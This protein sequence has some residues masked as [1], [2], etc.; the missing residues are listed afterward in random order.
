[1]DDKHF[2]QVDAQQRV[3]Q[4]QSFEQELRELENDDIVAL[5]P[6]QSEKIKHYH[7]QC[8]SSLSALY[9]VDTNH[10]SKQ[11][12]LGMKIASLFGA[13]TLAC[14]IVF[15][16]YQFWGYLTVPVQVTVLVLSPVVMFLLSLRFA[17]TEHTAYFSKIAA[18]LSLACF[19]LNLSMLG[20][21]FGV[22]PSPNAFLVWSGF[23]FILAYACNARLLL[24]FAITSLSSFIA[25]K[26]GTWS[27]LYWISFGDRPENFFIP[28][29]LLFFVPQ[30][31]NHAKL[32]GF[33]PVYRVLAMIMVF[34]PVLILSNW[35][36]ISYLNWSY[37]AIEVF[38]QIIGFALAVLAI[39]L[40]VK[41]SWNEVVQ[42]GNVFFMLFLYTKFYDWW[43]QWMPKS[44]FFLVLGLSA[45][46]ALFVFKRMRLSNHA[47][48]SNS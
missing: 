28:S 23:G 19:V 7:Q 27:G 24:F 29:L 14:S 45:L 15:L 18:L 44:V 47:L 1:M 39:L 41:K 13:V 35:G 4:I 30:L 37:D 12:T 26:V 3:D 42:T 34:L 40:G 20:K 38:Y 8:L 17:Q 32:T 33:G 46:L 48:G 10:Q 16:F 36:R 6:Q 2:S 5:S 21:I 25:M 31:F 22:T 11:L 43:W 9:D